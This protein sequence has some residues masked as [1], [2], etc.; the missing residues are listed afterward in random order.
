ML[1]ERET[2]ASK[3][4]QDSDAKRARDRG[5]VIESIRDLNGHEEKE[6]SHNKGGLS[7]AGIMCHILP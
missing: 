6:G 1:R 5:N 3:E 4:R 2:E 7:P